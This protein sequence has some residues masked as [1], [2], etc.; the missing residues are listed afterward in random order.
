M[1]IC[2]WKDSMTENFINCLQ[3][4]HKSYTWM[5]IHRKYRRLSDCRFVSKCLIFFLVQTKLDKLAVYTYCQHP[6]IGGERSALLSEAFCAGL[7]AALK[8]WWLRPMVANLSL[9]ENF[10]YWAN[11]EKYVGTYRTVAIVTVQQGFKALTENINWFVSLS[12]ILNLAVNSI[13]K[14]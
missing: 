9:L 1:Y 3:Q 7:T 11:T 12:D 14:F 2:K 6:V 10:F 5:W 8:I 13:Q 4:K